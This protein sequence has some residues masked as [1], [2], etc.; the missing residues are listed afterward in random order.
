MSVTVFFE[1]GQVVGMRPAPS[2]SYRESREAINS[3]TSIVSDGIP[4]DLTDPDSIHSIPVPDYL[5]P[6]PN[7]HI[8]ELGVT[9]YLEYVLRMHAGLL[10]VDGEFSLSISCLRQ[11][12]LLMLYSPIEWPKK[13]YYRIVN[14][15]ISLGRFKKANE[16]KRWIE[17]NV[18]SSNDL[19]RESFERT[20]QSCKYLDTDLIEVFSSG[21]CCSVCAKY[22]NRIYSCSGRDRRFPRFPQDFHFGCVLS[23]SPFV[24]GVMEPSFKCRDY[25]QYSNRPFVDDR[26]QKDLQA[27]ADWQDRVLQEHGYVQ[28]ADLNRIIYYWM[29]SAFPHDV[30]KS[31]SAFSRMRNANS[32]K[33]QALVQRFE[34]AGYKIPSSLEEAAKLDEENS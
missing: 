4:Y 3:A 13:D 22:R 32:P 34:A 10:W 11:A 30:P 16:W 19:A 15:L 2:V 24:D 8:I 9:G 26:T 25:V 27:Y 18:P 20:L 33:Y 1:H 6:N 31:L 12:C 7:A 5:L 29:K 14:D 21:P 17:K 23:H 28:S